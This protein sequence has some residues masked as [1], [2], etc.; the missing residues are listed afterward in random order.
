MFEC[1]SETIN[2]KIFSKILV[3]HA[4]LKPYRPFGIQY[5]HTCMRPS[6]L[7]DKIELYP[8]CILSW[9]C[10]ISPDS[11]AFLHVFCGNQRQELF[12]EKERE[13]FVVTQMYGFLNSKT[14]CTHNSYEM[15]CTYTGLDLHLL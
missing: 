8:Q 14:G 1:V 4:N 13:I 3:L 7:T 2:V 12:F 5:A 9:E 15:L 6:F 11:A 10:I